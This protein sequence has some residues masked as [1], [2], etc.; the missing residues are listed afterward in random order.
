ML[1]S[2]NLR[3]DEE[4]ARVNHELAAIESSLKQFLV[5]I[6]NEANEESKRNLEQIL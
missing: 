5:S 3:L 6:R 4:K 1:K 2:N